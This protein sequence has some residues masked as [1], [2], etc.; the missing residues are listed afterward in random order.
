M[1]VLLGWSKG[2]LRL[3]QDVS[4]VDCPLQRADFLAVQNKQMAALDNH[5]HQLWIGRDVY[6]ADPGV[7]ALYLLP[8]GC[9]ILSGDTDCLT[10]HDSHTGQRLLT[11]PAGVF[12]QDLCLIPGTELLAVCGGADGTVRLLTRRSLETVHIARVPGN[13]QRIDAARGALHV[14]C[15][16]EDDGLQC[17]LCRLSLRSLRYE[18]IASFPGIPGAIYA[19][20][21][22]GLWVCASEVLYHLSPGHATPDRIIPGFGLIRHMDWR[23]SQLL[24]T[25]P[26]M[27]I[28]ALVERCGTSHTILEGPVQQAIF[29]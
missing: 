28:C 29:I 14:L 27:E 13:A 18:P 4:R 17:L 7:E 21:T 25:D 16:T 1:A 24:I 5:A 8:W 9:L 2:I 12:P 6:P 20:F 22:G 3:D 11:A 15:L 19:E 10:L 26:V 23:G